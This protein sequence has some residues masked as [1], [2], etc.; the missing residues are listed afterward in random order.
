[1]QICIDIYS[2]ASRSKARNMSRLSRAQ[3][4]NIR[5]YREYY[6]KFAKDYEERMRKEAKLVADTMIKWIDL[7]GLKILDLGVG[8]GS[9][10]NQLYSKGISNIHVIGLDIAVGMLKTAKQKRIP[11]L[12]GLDM[13]VED[14]GYT[15]C[16]DMVCAHGFLKHCADPTIAVKKAHQALIDDGRFFVEDL[17]IEDDTLEIIKRL[18]P[19][20]EDY[21]KPN[22]RESSFYLADHELIRLVEKAGF[23][24][25]RYKKLVYP[26]AFESFDHIR[27]FFIDKTMFGIYT[28]K[29]I[30]YK[31]RKRCDE[32][33]LKTLKKVL[34]KPVLQRRTFISLFEKS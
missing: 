28:Y 6:S 11:W 22:E 32:I 17:S 9:V 12:E 25:L 30:P 13:R 2:F 27:D 19:K 10:W 14:L 16:F 1:M 31:H 4:E 7:N 34:E 23:Q 5:V 20:I 8:S 3:Q 21:L 33:F 29:T 18:R 26:L 24:M 15:D